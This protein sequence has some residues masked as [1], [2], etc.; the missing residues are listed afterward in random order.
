[1]QI[2]SE[3]EMPGLLNTKE[4]L[5]LRNWIHFL[6]TPEL[7]AVYRFSVD[8]KKCLYDKR[9]CKFKRYSVHC[10]G[11]LDMNILSADAG[12]TRQTEGHSF[13]D[14]LISE[15]VSVTSS[16]VIE[17]SVMLCSVS[18]RLVWVNAQSDCVLNTRYNPIH[19]RGKRCSWVPDCSSLNETFSL[20]WLQILQSLNL[21]RSDVMITND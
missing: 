17:A 4:I 10:V 19:G 13:G 1:M 15:S 18:L 11:L 3:G 2:R 20:H 5:Y 9:F 21:M 8:V 14:H 12:I 7:E 6:P 16:N